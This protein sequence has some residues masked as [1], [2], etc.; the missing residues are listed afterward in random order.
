[1]NC[2]DKQQEFQDAL[3][4]SKADFELE[5]KALTVDTETKAK[6]IADDFEA[7]N[8]L[9]AGVGAAAGTAVGGFFGGA[10]GAVA[11]EEVGKQIG[12][13]FTLKIG[14]HRESITIDVPQATMSTQDFSFDIPAVV[15]KDTDISFDLPV[16]VMRRQ[17]GPDVPQIK[18]V[19]ED[20]GFDLPFGGHVS[21]WVS[22]PHVEMVPTYLDLP[23][24]EMQPQHIVIGVPAVEMH[25][26][27]FK[28]DIPQISTVPTEFSA[29]IPYV[30][31]QFVK[32]AGR[33]TAALAT[34][35]AQD[36]QNAAAQKQ[37]AFKNRLRTDVAPLAIAMFACFKESIKAGRSE[38]A[39]RF[40][41]E[42]DK[43][44]NSVVALAAKGVP[45]NNSEMKAAQAVLA[46]AI[47]R[48]D[49]A[50]KPFDDSLAK[51]EASEKDSLQKFLGENDPVQPQ[52]IAA[53]LPS[54]VRTAFA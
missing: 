44:S 12:K 8:D 54:L 18:M 15:M 33:K 2:D 52:R 13:L 20:H 47:N 21:V 29:D 4:K 42:I 46:D 45:E 34:A 11:G 37:A 31:I 9:A 36:A 32:D 40:S 10:P 51:L 22:V 27:D 6:Q 50:L 14:S 17:R 23:T 3:K 5:L 7:D 43:L 1:M 19:N 39:G 41:S 49:L 26:E 25:R 48:R 53:G 24:N 35:L 28:I 16:I 38:A 30:T